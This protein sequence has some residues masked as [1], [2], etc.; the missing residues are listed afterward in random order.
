MNATPSVIGQ[1]KSNI[2]GLTYLGF[3]SE[4]NGYEAYGISRKDN[5]PHSC[6]WIIFQL[7]P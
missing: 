2:G 1:L 6:R 3:V 7:K 5:P 4:L